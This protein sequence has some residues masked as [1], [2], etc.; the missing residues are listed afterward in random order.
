MSDALATLL[1]KQAITEQLYRYCRSFDR[2]DR[3]LALSI[4]HADGTV[5]YGNR[6]TEPI[7]VYLGPSTEYRWTLNNCSHQITNILIEVKNTR[8]VSEAYVTASLQEQEQDGRV[9][10]NLFRGRYVDRWSY[11]DDKWAID[12]R[13]F[14]PDSYTRIDTPAFPLPVFFEV[15]SR[16]R[17]D[18]SYLA[19]AELHA[20]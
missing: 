17:E 18:P 11:R 14:I 10:E 12:H 2:M 5:Q 20:G 4:W 1:A 8:A 9:M 15:G 19:W 6:P 3:E 13:L 16:D 7:E